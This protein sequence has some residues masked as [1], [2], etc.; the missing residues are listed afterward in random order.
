[1]KDRLE[2]LVIAKTEKQKPDIESENIKAEILRIDDEIRKL[3]DKLEDADD[4]LFGYIQDRVKGLHDRKS[5]LE[6]K[7]RSTVRKHKEIDTAPLI[8]LMSRWDTL[9]VTEEHN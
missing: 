5:A 7:L 9:A 4:V 3:M 1:M 2:N 8:D 6:E